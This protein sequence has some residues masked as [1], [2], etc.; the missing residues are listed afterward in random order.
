MSSSPT[1]FFGRC[2]RRVAS[3]L[4]QS[5]LHSGTSAG[6]ASERPAITGRSADASPDQHA[7]EQYGDQEGVALLS[8]I[9]SAY[10]AYAVHHSG[11]PER[12]YAELDFFA[13][14]ALGRADRTPAAAAHSMS[15]QY[16]IA[17]L[18]ALAESPFLSKAFGHGTATD[19][20]GTHGPEAPPDWNALRAPFRASEV[21]L[22][23]P[24][25]PGD[26]P[27]V[28]LGTPAIA[29]VSGERMR[30]VLASARGGELS[31]PPSCAP[32]VLEERFAGCLSERHW[33]LSLLLS[34]RGEG[35]TGSYGA[36][37]AARLSI[38]P[39]RGG[40]PEAATGYSLA[41]VH[42]GCDAL[43]SAVRSA[44][45]QL[46]IGA[47]L[48]G[49]SRIRVPTSGSGRDASGFLVSARQRLIA[50]GLAAPD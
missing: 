29:P 40:E 35:S 44:A 48:D 11:D 47:G 4:S 5:S 33:Q 10:L 39:A 7:A 13:E 27:L 46:G 34:Q 9:S 8:R 49:R 23:L 15:Y 24:E 17:Y 38:A 30:R 32:T 12:A 22:Y 2:K 25:R 6:K 19:E 28:C 16:V 45:A 37:L 42:P 31:S 20:G 43:E 3:L 21:D 1:H 50:S 18:T 14:L 26:H 36:P 41:G